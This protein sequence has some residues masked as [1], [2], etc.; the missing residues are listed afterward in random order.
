MSQLEEAAKRTRA[1]GASDAWYGDADLLLRGVVG[2]SNGFLFQQLI[3]AADHEDLECANLFRHGAQMLGELVSSGIGT[4]C[5]GGEVKSSGELWTKHV[6]H[7]K[8][9][10]KRLQ[11]ERDVDPQAQRQCDQR[12]H[13]ATM[14]DAALGRMSRPVPIDRDDAEGILLQ[15]R[16]G[17]EQVFYH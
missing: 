4:P 3:Q 14:K 15:P 2:T 8:A 1:C 11:T 6:A 7:N 12:V 9:L 13:E 17:V 5:E 16:F 10:C